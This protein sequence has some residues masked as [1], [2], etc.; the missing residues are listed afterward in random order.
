M[1]VVIVLVETSNSNSS[2]SGDSKS[3]IG[4]RRSIKVLILQ[5]YV[6]YD[7]KISKHEVYINSIK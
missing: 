6:K 5:L 7:F 3:N 4:I 2:S 1:A